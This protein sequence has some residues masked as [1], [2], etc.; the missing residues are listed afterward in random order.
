MIRQAVQARPVAT[1]SAASHFGSIRACTCRWALASLQQLARL[2]AF[3]LLEALQ[4][5]GPA[6]VGS[7]QVLE[8]LLDLLGGPG[9]QRDAQ[10]VVELRLGQPTLGQVLA[11]QL[12][13]L[14]ALV[15]PDPQRLELRHR[16]SISPDVGLVG[17][18]RHPSGRRNYSEVAEEEGSRSVRR[19]TAW[20]G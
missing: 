18:D 14:V 1:P 4:L 7:G 10:P 16:L 6:R 19:E 8:E 11:E 5:L 12:D 15:V 17:H 20:A 13:G 3:L 9:L 2:P